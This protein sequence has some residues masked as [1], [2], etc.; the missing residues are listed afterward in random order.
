[1]RPGLEITVDGKTRLSR[2]DKVPAVN[3]GGFRLRGLNTFVRGDIFSFFFFPPP[4]RFRSDD[5][6][7]SEETFPVRISI[8]HA[9]ERKKIEEK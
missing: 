6:S 3:T 2:D 9:I 4:L 8:F 1:M 5:D 7:T